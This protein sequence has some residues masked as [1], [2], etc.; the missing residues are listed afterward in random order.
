MNTELTLHMENLP[1]TLELLQLPNGIQALRYVDQR[2]LPT[3][4]KHCTTSNWMQVVGAIKTLALRGAP[5]IGVAGAAALSLWAASPRS[6]LANIQST[7]SM[8]SRARP[9]AVA[10][11][12]AVDRAMACAQGIMDQG[13]SREDV[14]GALFNLVKSME[15]EDEALNRVL[16]EEG[17][18]L[19]K[20]GS[21]I[22]THCNAGSLATVFFGTALGVVYTAA[23]QGKVAHVYADETRPVCQGSRLTT[24]ELARVGVPVTCIC[25]NMAASLM[26]QGKVDA[27]LVG[28]DR[29]AANGDTANK[30]G[31]YGVA[32]LAKHHNIPFY[33]AAP[34][35]TID[36]SL[37]DGSQ[38]PIENRA[39]AEVLP[40]PIEDV[41]VWNP[42]FDVTPHELISGIIT[43]TGVWR[44]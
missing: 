16:G 19:L 4:L 41:E 42:A 43:E 28:A 3:E 2:L 20:P 10:L 31:T 26:A 23:A 27:V 15:Q 9:T 6:N 11:S 33:V 44:P 30:I 14:A 39:A 24:W 18:K 38:I 7:A 37:A 29:I 1:R 36:Q 40:Q 21:N 35:S 13:G 32:V 8:I 22:L 5:A 34:A 25:D 17:A 12:W